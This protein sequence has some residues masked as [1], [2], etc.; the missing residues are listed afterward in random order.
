MKRNRCEGAGWRY[1]EFTWWDMID[2]P[3]EVVAQVAAALEQ[4]A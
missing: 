2:D 4:A 3:A 1:L